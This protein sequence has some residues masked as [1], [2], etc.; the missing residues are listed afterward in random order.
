MAKIAKYTAQQ[1]LA[2][3]SIPNTNVRSYEGAALEGLGAAVGNIAEFAAQREQQKENFKAEDGYRKLQLRLGE[4]LNHYADNMA[5]DGTGFHDDF[6]KNVYS[7]AR[8]AFLASLPPRLRER[9]GTLLA[10]DGSDT[11]AWSIKAATRERDQTYKWYD[12]A[13]N[14]SKEQLATAISVDPDA[15]DALLQQGMDEIERSGLPTDRKAEHRKAWERMAQIAHL[16]RML[17]SRPEEVLRDLG[18]DPRMLSPTSQF[19]LLR[20]ALIQQ[21]SGGDASAISPKGAVGLMQVMPNTAREIARELGDEGFDQSWSDSFVVAYLSNPVVNQRYGDHYLRKQIRAFGRTGG[22]EAALIAYNGGPERAKKWIESGFDDSVLPAETRKYYKAIMSRLPGLGIGNGAGEAASGRSNP[23]NVKIV[24]PTQNVSADLQDRVKASFAGLGIENVRISS[25]FRSPAKNKAV[26]GAERSQHMH[27]NAMDIDVSGYSHAERVKIIRSLSANGITGIGVGS[28]I[29]H[30]DLGGRRAWGY[31]TAAGGG[32]VPKWAQEAIAEHLEGR[33]TAPAARTTGPA[34]R[35]ASLP[36]DDRQKFIHSADRAVSSALTASMKATAVQKQ[37]IRTAIR[38]EL[39]TLETT[40]QSTEAVDDTAVSTVLGEDDYIRFVESRERALRIYEAKKGI[41]T[42]SFEDMEQRL[43][44][45]QP[46]PGSL[47]FATDQQVQAAVQKEIDR[48]T[49]LR[50]TKPD[51]AALEYE[52]VR[53]AWDAIKDAENPSPEAVHEYVRLNL[54]RQ[55]EF[56][57]KPGSEA[58]VPRAWAMEIGRSIG[59]LPEL[60]GRNAAEVRAAIMLHYESLERV[61]GEYTDEVILHAM[62]VYKGVGPNTGKLIDGMMKS[63]AAGGDPFARIRQRESQARDAD[64][65]EEF[66]EGPGFF[67][68]VRNL[69]FGDA[70]PEDTGPA[71]T[72]EV[73]NEAVLR[74]M[75]A[76][77]TYGNALSPEEETALRARYGDR[78]FDTAVSR[79]GGD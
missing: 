15:Y 49:R 55:R 29:I 11:E 43:L 37:E 6:L 72:S 58:P 45:Y 3:P 59:K 51:Q 44:D 34:G 66:S 79:L 46:E 68:T 33:A 78:A 61:F 4:D 36:Y 8:N 41:S 69:I 21:E 71:E 50:S 16:N 39:A 57:I 40:G 52:D 20:N 30:A 2:T 13:L 76:I 12:S 47:T 18:A 70:E 22:L 14:V 77:Q 60:S 56:G 9:Y 7:P 25:G 75:A 64:Q 1:G 48:V 5:E 32:E 63:I 38:N 67:G 74:A 35:Y 53:A 65:V 26:G 19:G 42:M 28:N 27:G 10:D 31:K 23:A 17:E 54:E 73:N 24:G 62:S